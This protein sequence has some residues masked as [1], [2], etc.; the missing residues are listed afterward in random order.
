MKRT[1]LAVG[2]VLLSSLAGAQWSTDLVLTLSGEYT[3]VVSYSWAKVRAVPI[4]GDLTFGNFV[5]VWPNRE[6]I[7]GFLVYR[8]FPLG[9][10]LEAR[11]GAA[12]TMRPSQKAGAGAG[13]GLFVG[14]SLKVG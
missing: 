2:L 13:A 11:I 1:A 9:P 6:A 7:G 10:D 8:Q 14:F 4:V 3:P 5:G 12:W